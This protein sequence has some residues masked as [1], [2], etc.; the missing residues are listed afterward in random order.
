MVRQE[1]KKNS[2]QTG[3][4][5]GWNPQAAVDIVVLV[6]KPGVALAEAMSRSG[7]ERSVRCQKAGFEAS[8]LSVCPCSE[9]GR[10]EMGMVLVEIKG[11]SKTR[12]LQIF[13]KLQASSIKRGSNGYMLMI[14]DREK[15]AERE[16]GAGGTSCGQAPQDVEK[17]FIL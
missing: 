7:A 2:P 17:V 15:R 16:V 8:R 9:F 1:R 14:G 12:D 13:V 3:T 11:L 6:V 5:P 4:K 10:M